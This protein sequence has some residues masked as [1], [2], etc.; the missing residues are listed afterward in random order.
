MGKESEVSEQ[1]E[2][3]ILTP[4]L[5]WATLEYYKLEHY[6]MSRQES[7]PGQAESSPGQPKSSSAQQLK[8][9]RKQ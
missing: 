9:L 2:G 1:D 3:S 6:N 4:L 5:V 8:L 7:S